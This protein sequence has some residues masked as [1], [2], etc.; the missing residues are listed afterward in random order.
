[1]L[2][3]TAGP[4]HNEKRFPSSWRS[5]HNN[6]NTTLTEMF[7]LFRLCGNDKITWQITCE[8]FSQ[9]QLSTVFTFASVNRRRL[10][11]QPVLPL[12]FPWSLICV[13]HSERLSGS[14]QTIMLILLWPLIEFG[15]KTDEW[16]AWGHDKD[17]Y[18]FTLSLE[19]RSVRPLGLDSLTPCKRFHW[20]QSFS[21]QVSF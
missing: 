3:V 7:P 21:C 13:I 1:M 17:V 11:K 9:L 5:L 12:C 6:T 4:E 20:N 10:H 8:M 14:G 19:G 18:T 16:V 15:E 2:G